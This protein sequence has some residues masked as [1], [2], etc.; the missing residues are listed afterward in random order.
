MNRLT[1]AA[2]QITLLFTL[3][4]S[5]AFSF[6]QGS[7]NWGRIANTMHH[8]EK[9][10]SALFFAGP[11]N[12]GSL[13]L[14]TRHPVS[15]D[16]DRWKDD[17]HIDATLKPLADCGLN[18]IKLSYWGHGGE[19]DA[20]CPTWLFSQHRWPGDTGQGDYSEADQIS[21][22]KRFFEHAASNHLLVAPMLEVSPKFPFYAEFPDNIGNLVDRSVWLLHNFGNE[23]NY[24]SVYDSQGTPRKVIWLIETIHGSPI[25][26]E[27]FASGFGEAAIQIKQ[28]TGYDV[29]FIIDPTPLPAYGSEAGPDPVALMRHASILAIDPFNI[30]SQGVKYTSDISSISDD[31]RQAYCE[32]VL[33][34]W[35]ASSIPLI[36]PIMPGYDG[37][38]VF[39]G[40]PVY[41]FTDSWRAKQK[42]LAVEYET[43]GISIDIWNGWTEGY[44]IPPSVEDGDANTKW[45]QDVVA[46]AKAS[47]Q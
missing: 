41:G 3:A 43:D 5:S 17:A 42:Q 34:K 16:T 36:A 24:L 19:T 31:D 39:K 38:I 22:G 18:T 29:G 1:F 8:G 21:Q 15:G 4:V 33:A 35:R 6:A 11:P 26:P 28:A 13:G 44:A 23:P 27:R 2:I 46:S 37:H 7:P 20:S 47:G 12:P 10:Y 9:L 30:T 32:S 45:A 25:D 40:S 14:Y